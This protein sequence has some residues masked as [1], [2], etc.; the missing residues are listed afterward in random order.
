[1]CHFFFFFSMG[2]T[3]K[4]TENILDTSILQIFRDGWGLDYLA[5][6]CEDSKH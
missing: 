2:K 5:E 1:M 6:F 4:G 3:K